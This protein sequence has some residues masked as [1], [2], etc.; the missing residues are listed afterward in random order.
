MLTCRYNSN[1]SVTL[2]SVPYGVKPTS[3]STN[4]LCD[5]LNRVHNPAAPLNDLLQQKPNSTLP[6]APSGLQKMLTSVQTA[7][8][9]TAALVDH[10]ESPPAMGKAMHEKTQLVRHRNRA[11]SESIQASLP[12]KNTL[13]VPL[14]SFLKSKSVGDMPN[15]HTFEYRVDI[16]HDTNFNNSEKAKSESFSA[17]RVLKNPD[18]FG[19][20]A[21]KLSTKLH[22]LI[23][24]IDNTNY[25]AMDFIK[26]MEKDTSP[27]GQ[28]G[29]I[30]GGKDEIIKVLEEENKTPQLFVKKCL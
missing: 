2:A 8:P 22:D 24:K 17:A 21:D 15:M 3:A 5:S 9:K 1:S 20:I 29:R 25:F 12:E 4:R 26:F 13:T 16:K 19:K 27:D 11:L 6:Q 18:L 14:A 23:C 30:I 10:G 7:L 28:F